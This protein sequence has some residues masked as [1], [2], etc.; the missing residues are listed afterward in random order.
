M[1]KYVLDTNVASEILRPRPDPAV[2]AWLMQQMPQDICL[3]AGTVAELHYGLELA[4]RRG[5]ADMAALEVK[6][7]RLVAAAEILPLDAAAAA[8]LGRLWANPDLLT[9]LVTQPAARQVASGGDLLI[10]AIAIRP[11]ATLVT[12]D[13]ADFQRIGAMDGGLRLHDPFAAAPP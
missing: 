11:D 8:I 5:R 9:F 7:G 3:S 2:S 6:V 12:R 13:T 1:T 10:A 4:R